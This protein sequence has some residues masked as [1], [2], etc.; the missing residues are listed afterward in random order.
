M[1][2]HAV[3]SKKLNGYKQALNQGFT[4][5]FKSDK[6]IFLQIKPPYFG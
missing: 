3:S 6:R 4:V 5:V 2:G 1:V